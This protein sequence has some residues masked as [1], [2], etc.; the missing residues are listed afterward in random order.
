MQDLEA[1]RLRESLVE[2]E[3]Y[4]NEIRQVTRK[5]VE[6]LDV[7]QKYTDQ[8]AAG[9]QNLAE[10]SIEGI[11]RVTT[12]SAGGLRKIIETGTS[13]LSRMAE[14][15]QDSIN[16]TAQECMVR[17]QNYTKEGLLRLD[18]AQQK[19]QETA[20]QVSQIEQAILELLKQSDDFTHKENV[21]VYRN[22]QAVV[23]D[24]V[25][26]QTEAIAAQNDELVRRNEHLQKQ[27]RG[28][29]P[30][31]IITL[32]TALANIVLAAAQIAGL[33]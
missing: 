18:E 7:I 3:N 1:K 4:L 22:V 33:F 32:V 16:R 5:N 19:N 8:S 12:E 24:E 25:K 21:K 11:Q 27:G 29:R 13:N 30:L 9:M 6:A 17:L 20:E 31:M 15:S 28:L 23:V 2:Y 26:K 10:Q 14:G